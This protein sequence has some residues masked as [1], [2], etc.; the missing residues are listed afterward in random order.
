MN[1][2][3]ADTA[4]RENSDSG[5]TLNPAGRFPLNLPKSR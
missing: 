3:D 5:T 1:A 2:P 4:T